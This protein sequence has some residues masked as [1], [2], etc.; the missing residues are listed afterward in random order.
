MNLLLLAIFTVVSLQCNAQKEETPLSGGRYECLYE[1]N[2]SSQNGNVDKYF[3]I[4][5]IGS[6]SARFVDYTQYEVDS[7]SFLKGASSE[8]KEKYN[9]QLMKNE[10][11]FDQTVYQ[12]SPKGKVSVYSTIGT[13]F[14]KYEEGNYPIKWQLSEDT[15][16]VCGY[17]CKKAVGTYGGYQWTAWY[18]PQ[19]QVSFGPWKFCGLPGLVLAVSD[20]EHIH[21]FEAIAFRKSSILIPNMKKSNVISTTRADFIKAKNAFEKDPLKNIPVESIGDVTIRK[22]EGGKASFL[23]NGVQLRLHPNGYVPLEKE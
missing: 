11:F 9:I 15:D 7:V 12:N 10:M 3:T 23:I 18:A 17:V 5:Q 20:S 22:F 8:D 16:T 6:S 1:Y 14:Y 19:I 21:R 13:D 2:V 4:L